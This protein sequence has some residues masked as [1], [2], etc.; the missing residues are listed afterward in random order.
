MTMVS[1]SHRFIF[2]HNVKV[3]GNSIKKGSKECNDT[4]YVAFV[5]RSLVRWMDLDDL[6]RQKFFP[7][8]L[9]ALPKHLKARDVRGMASS[10]AVRQFLKFIFVSQPM[11]WASLTLPLHTETTNPSQ[12][13]N[14]EVTEKFRRVRAVESRWKCQAAE[15]STHG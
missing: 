13:Q 7:D 3:P 11:G 2:F 15:R 1:H 6:Y 14:G 9:K 5:I 10:E 4:L 8:R 12:T